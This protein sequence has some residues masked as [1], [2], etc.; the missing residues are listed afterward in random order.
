MVLRWL[1]SLL[2]VAAVTLAYPAA[3]SAAAL[4]CASASVGTAAAPPMKSDCPDMGKA[5][6]GLACA[7]CVAVVAAMATVAAPHP[8][9]STPASLQ[10][11]R[12]E[13]RGIQPEPPPPR[14]G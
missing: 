12:L 8:A 4:D 14:L 5:H 9:T 13:A 10:L 6:V 1:L 3:S 7:S 11:A 2:V